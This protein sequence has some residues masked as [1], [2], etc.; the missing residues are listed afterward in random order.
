LF[1]SIIP[2]ILFAMLTA[3]LCRAHELGPRRSRVPASRCSRTCAT[4]PTVRASVNSAPAVGGTGNRH[5][6]A[7]RLGRKATCLVSLKTVVPAD[8]APSMSSRMTESPAW[9]RERKYFPVRK[10]STMNFKVTTLDKLSRFL[11]ICLEI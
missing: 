10:K 9:G 3:A 4:Q 5:Y 1:S 2:K 11:Y 8:Y 6:T 7:A